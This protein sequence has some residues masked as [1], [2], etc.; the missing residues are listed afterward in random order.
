MAEAAHPACILET[1]KTAPG[2]RLTDKWAVREF[3]PFSF[4]LPSAFPFKERDEKKKENTILKEEIFNL[5][6]FFFLFFLFKQVLIGGG[7]NHRLGL[8]DMVMIKD[9]HISVAGG[10]SS[11]LKSVDEYLWNNNL[12][13]PVEV[14]KH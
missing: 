8:F 10:V 3:S 11:A 13:V 7:K 2:L 12:S 5:I 4:L 6:V 14:S 1:R 9:N